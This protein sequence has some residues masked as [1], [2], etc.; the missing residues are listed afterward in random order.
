[1]TQAS[2]ASVSHEQIKCVSSEIQQVSINSIVSRK[3]A[4]LFS[5][6]PAEIRF[7]PAPANTGIVFRRTDLLGAPE[8]QANVFN[9]KSTPRCTIIGNGDATIQTVEHVLAA[10]FALGID[11]LII[12]VSGPE[13]PIFDG[14]SKV[15][16]EMMSEAKIT[17]LDQKRPVYA[18]KK[19][20]YY[21]SKDIQIVALPA[22]AFR[23]SY[24]LHYP[25]SSLIGTQ[26]ISLDVN[27]ITF[28][29]EIAAC[30]TFSLYEEIVP[31]MQSGLLKGGSLENAVLIKDDKVANPEGLRFSN[32]MVR[33]KVLDLI[34]DLSL[35]GIRFHAHIIALRSGHHAN[36]E[37]AKILYNHLTMESI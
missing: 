28:Q 32:E 24:T 25:N 8:I 1:M 35:V 17:S 26:F 23:V 10:T 30:R 12:E 29:S 18:L 6:A 33:H 11:N 22:D 15:F 31:F 21:S 14:S 20:L 2:C 27:E 36:S 37:F 9:V 34:G 3:G 7:L 5:G 16:V 19:P 13:V 4:G